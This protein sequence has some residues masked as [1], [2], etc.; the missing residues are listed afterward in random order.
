[1]FFVNLS[2][3]VTVA[4]LVMGAV[5][6]GRILRETGLGGSCVV[7]EL[8]AGHPDVWHAC[9][10]GWITGSPKLSRFG[11]T[12]AAVRDEHEIWLCPEEVAR[13]RREQ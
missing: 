9:K 10:D 6:D 12:R 3:V 4:I 8:P 5:K 13:A 7:I 1:M 2:V 11:C